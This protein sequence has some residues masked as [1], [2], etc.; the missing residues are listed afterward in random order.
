MARR[1]LTLIALTATTATLL[2]GQSP[3]PRNVAMRP[4]AQRQLNLGRTYDAP[5]ADKINPAPRVPKPVIISKTEWNGG[6]SSGTMRSQFPRELT[7]H[8]LGSPKPLT[9]EDDPAQQLRNLQIYGWREKAWADLPY[10][11]L[12][13]LD[14]NIYEG[15]DPMKAGDTN[16]SYDPGNKLLCTLMGN[17]GLQAPTAKQLDSM[18]NLM[19]WASDYY[20]IDPGT[21]KG[22]M[23]FTSTA[24]PGQ[25][26]YPYVAS[27]YF[28]GQVRQKIS[29]AYK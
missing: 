8:H 17:T 2:H 14:G 3:D 25:Y 4:Q 28:E 26:L 5:G 7:V 18:V 20:N 9:P 11:F 23:E 27:G 10:H 22:H 16:T 1:L 21:I 6:E 24:C 12:I 15:R 13:D 19:A 29:Q